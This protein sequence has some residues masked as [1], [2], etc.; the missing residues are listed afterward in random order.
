MYPKLYSMKLPLTVLAFSSL[1]VGCSVA[2]KESAAA[3][4]PTVSVDLVESLD[5]TTSTESDA[6]TGPIAPLTINDAGHFVDAQGESVRFWGVNLVALYPSRAQ[7]DSIAETLAERQVNLARPHH[8]LRHSKDWVYGM[9][10][11][12]LVKYE[13]D[14]RQFDL[15]A[16]DR[17]DYLNAKLREKGIYLAM[18]AHFSRSYRAGDASILE[19]DEADALAWGEA[20]T[21]LNSWHWKKA[22]DVKKNMPLIDERSALVSEE[23]IRKLLEHKNPYTGLTYAED[24]QVLTMEVL[25]ESSLEYAIICGNRFPDYFQQ[26]LDD[27]WAEFCAERGKAPGDLYKV[28]GEMIAVR[29][30][31]FRYLDEKFF[32]R[33]KATIAA[34]GS[35]VPMTYSNLWRGENATKMHWETSDWVE[36]HSYADPRLAN[37]HEDAISKVSRNRLL[38]KPFF[39]GELNQAEGGDNIQK[40]KPYRTMLQAGIVAYGLFQDWDGL[41]WFAWNHGDRSVLPDGSAK[42]PD[43]DAHLG[44]MLRDNM[45]QDHLRSLGYIFRNELIQPSVDPITVWIDDPIYAGDYHGLMR[46]KNN[47]KAGWQNIHGVRKAYGKEP[48]EQASAPWFQH[49]PRNPLLADTGEIIKDMQRRYIAASAP[50]T[51]IFSG[52]NDAQAVDILKCLS[53]ENAGDF[54][55]VV[56]VTQDGQLI[57]Q[58]S[59]LLLSRTAITEDLK[60]TTGE[61]YLQTLKRPQGGQTW[62]MRV[63][64]TVSTKIPEPTT[65]E[66]NAAGAFVLPATD[67]TEC[68][69]IL[70]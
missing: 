59:H 31:F 39:I 2:E 63:N 69:L 24:P 11:N 12:S 19:T 45:M 46:G 3:L 68:E 37:R 34:T 38:N 26:K 5:Q 16:L 32:N 6:P 18:S 15:E 42:D 65:L 1:L 36:N 27:Q 44:D 66:V 22:I 21:E 57:A 47:Y 14:S 43:R 61:I 35:T 60:E 70:E 58:S 8:M 50:Q 54:I 52:M 48:T 30:E 41:V 23:F 7:A 51:E 17:F 62:H 67:W 33:I 49:G 40:Q 25:N 29:A 53:V 55:T 28:S 4:E 10:G 64:R 13:E 20:M 56:L 9:E